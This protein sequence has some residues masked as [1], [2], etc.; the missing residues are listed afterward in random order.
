MIFVTRQLY[1]GYQHGSGWERRADR[2]GRLRGQWW[3]YD[4]AHLSSH[5]RFSLH[6]MFDKS[7]VEI[8]ADALEIERL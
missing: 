5:S 8:D 3:L 6:V 4:E 2:P 1:E 7:D